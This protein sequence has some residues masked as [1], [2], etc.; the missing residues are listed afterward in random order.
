MYIFCTE[1]AY[2]GTMISSKEVVI[3]PTVGVNEAK[4]GL[5]LGNWFG[6]EIF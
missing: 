1:K 2:L 3:E 4:I 5:K 6:T